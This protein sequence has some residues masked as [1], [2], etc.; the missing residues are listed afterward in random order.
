M[1]L[2]A[3][4]PVRVYAGTSIYGG[5]F[6]DEFAK[7]SRAFFDRAREG[8]FR[9]VVSALVEDELT[10]APVEVRD[11]F[12]RFRAGADSVAVTGEAVALR[13]AYLDAGIV[14]PKFTND[15]LHVALA[16]VAECG[17]IVSWNFRHIVHYQ[18]VPLYN[19]VNALKRY[20]ALDIRSP[21]E[22]IEN[23]D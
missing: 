3:I 8:Y 20:A 4:R 9:L 5:V 21:L 14:A 23:E 15:A 13:Q 11:W 7:P 10:E 1:T 16:T 18:K 6:D 2:T 17:I 12:T 22:V 19:A